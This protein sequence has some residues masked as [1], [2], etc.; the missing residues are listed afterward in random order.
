MPLDDRGKGR[1]LGV[2]REGLRFL[3][4]LAGAAGLAFALGLPW[5]GVPA[6]A[7]AAGVAGFFRDPERVPPPVSDAVLAPAD[8]KVV[9]VVPFGGWRGPDGEPLTQIGIFMSPLDVHVNRAPAAGT[10]E[11]VERRPGRFL[12]AWDTA[13]SLENEQAL[14]HLRTAAGDIWMK[15]IA[16]VLARRIVTWVRPGDKVEAGE[17]IGLI[18]FGSRVDLILPARFSVQVRPGQRTAAGVTVVAVLSVP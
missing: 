5:L 14:I 16:G 12:A 10:V 9:E 18:R 8:G 1:V 3:V 7:L 17:R 2:A 15:Q 6:L 13:A 4:P 11:A